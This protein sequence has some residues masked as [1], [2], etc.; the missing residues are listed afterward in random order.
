NKSR[1]ADNKEQIEEIKN[2]KEEGNL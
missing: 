1:I 2:G